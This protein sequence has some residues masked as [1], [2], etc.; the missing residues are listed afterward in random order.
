MQKK[1][2]REKNCSRE[3]ERFSRAGSKERERERE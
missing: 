2:Q 3:S 1:K